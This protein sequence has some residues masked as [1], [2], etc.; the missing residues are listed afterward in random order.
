MALKLQPDPTFW[1]AVEIT[2]PGA[3]KPARIDLEF[4]YKN[5]DEMKRFL[6]GLRRNPDREDDEILGE[7]IR[8]WRH[9]EEEYS[10]AAL[11]TLLTNYLAAGREILD[12]YTTAHT[13][14]RQKNS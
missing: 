8:N 10:P 3:E 5:K 4:V 7:I 1:S 9:V 6:E 12:A 2:V 11:R 13:A 14:S